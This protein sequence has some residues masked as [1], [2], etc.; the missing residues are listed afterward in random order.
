MPGF[1]PDVRQ[2]ALDVFFDLYQPAIMPVGRPDHI[3]NA[4]DQERRAVRCGRRPEVGIVPILRANE[5]FA[6]TRAFR[7]QTPVTRTPI[8]ENPLKR[9][10]RKRH[11]GGVRQSCNP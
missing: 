8:A 6:L 2:I 3:R 11:E 7:I 1:S 10:C 4:A 9:P 5:V